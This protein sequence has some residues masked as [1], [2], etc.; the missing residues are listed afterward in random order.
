M[1]KPLCL[2]FY[3]VTNADL[4]LHLDDWAEFSFLDVCSGL[5]FS[6]RLML[7]YRLFLHST[8]TRQ[9]TDLLNQC[10]LVLINLSGTPILLQHPP[11]MIGSML[12][13]RLILRDVLLIFE[14]WPQLHIWFVDMVC[15]QPTIKICGRKHAG[16]RLPRRVTLSSVLKLQ[17]SS[18]L[19]QL[20]SVATCFHLY[21]V[22]L[23]KAVHKDI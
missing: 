18:T 14:A 16:Q 19:D 11:P 12:Y 2:P 20:K 7:Q 15:A 22:D 23:K 10:S 17:H 21:K 8:K 3:R 13:F 5:R 4:H 9:C 1:Y 6:S